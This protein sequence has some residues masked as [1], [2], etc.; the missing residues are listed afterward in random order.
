MKFAIRV[1]GNILYTAIT[2]PWE[3]RLSPGDTLRFARRA[4]ELG[5]DWLWV[6]EHIIQTPERVAALGSRFFDAL[7]TAALLLG[8]TERIRVLTY[9]SVLPYHNPVLYAKQLSTVDFLSGGRITPGLA[10]G[11]LEREFEILRV[12][13]SERGRIADE[14][15]RAMKELWTSERPRF[16]GKYVQFE[17]IVFEPKPVQKPHPP[18]L[19][20]G[21]SRPAIRRAA[22][23]GD[24]WLPWLT[25]REELPSRLAYLYEQPGMQQRSRAYEVLALLADFPADDRLNLRKF[26][27]PRDRDEIL[28]MTG[29]LREAG[30]TGAIVHL[31]PTSGLD[32][33]LEWLGGFG[34]EI[35]PAFSE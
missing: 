10:V 4:E 3:A 24:G 23:L 1:P 18:L 2:S 5:F 30:A 15:L 7:T 12:P 9:I 31:P 33:C 13:C 6:S 20:G 27:I 32:E 29:R 19:L 28:E 14:S 25:T 17:D 16:H 22:N 21:D 8:A 11:Y 26:R 35:I 34:E